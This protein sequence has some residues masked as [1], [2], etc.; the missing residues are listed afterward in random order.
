MS[1]SDADEKKK[2]S[3]GSQAKEVAGEEKD[4]IG[5]A[6]A[7]RFVEGVLVRGEAEKPNPDGK[8]PQNATH[9]IVEENPDGT[10]KIKRARFK[11]F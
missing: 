8:L 5:N 4:A 9:A 2:V 7:E 10:T 1:A 6:S 11:A 3:K